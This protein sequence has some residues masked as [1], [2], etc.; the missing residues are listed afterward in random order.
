MLRISLTYIL[1][2]LILSLVFSY[3]TI[4]YPNYF[5]QFVTNKKIKQILINRA[6]HSYRVNLQRK[7][8]LIFKILN[9]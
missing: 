8:S 6:T 7:G 1:V 3:M 4:K 5:N 2:I 9:V